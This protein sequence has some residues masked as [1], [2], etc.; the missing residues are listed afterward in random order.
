MSVQNV[1]PAFNAELLSFEQYFRQCLEGWRQDLL[2]I[3]DR[4]DF[5]ACAQVNAIQSVLRLSNSNLAREDMIRAYCFREKPESIDGIM[6]MLIEARQ[7]YAKVQQG[8][9][10]Q[11]QEAEA[12]KAKGRAKPE[13]FECK[14]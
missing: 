11:L 6:G 2:G 8:I 4:W 1:T 5:E 3:N 9:E 7:D 10:R 12:S 13:G 14:Q